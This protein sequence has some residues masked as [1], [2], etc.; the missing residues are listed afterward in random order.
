M[1]VSIALVFYVSTN[2]KIKNKIYE[3]IFRHVKFNYIIVILSTLQQRANKDTRAT[4]SPS[5][6]NRWFVDQ[7]R[8]IT[9][10]SDNEDEPKEDQ[11]I[12]TNF[13]KP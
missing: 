3:K 6:I 4:D 13:H 5:N 8:I 1:G 2:C 10:T 7:I 12:S 9:D 11:I